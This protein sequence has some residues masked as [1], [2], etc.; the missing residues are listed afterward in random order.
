MISAAIQMAGDLIAAMIGVPPVGGAA[1]AILKP[2][3]TDVFLAFMHWKDLGRK[4]TLGDFCYQERWA[5]GSDRAYTLSAIV[6]LRTSIWATRQTFT[7]RLE[8]ADG[9]PWLVGQRGRGHFYLGHRVGSVPKGTPKGKIYV[10]RVT[11]IGLTWDRQTT[12]TWQVIIGER[13]MEDPILKALKKVK[14]IAGIARDL[15]VL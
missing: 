12:P 9:A 11:E 10:D 13:V 8:V 15:G 1:D 2:L 3:Y 6:A 14:E 7:H 5:E 4:A